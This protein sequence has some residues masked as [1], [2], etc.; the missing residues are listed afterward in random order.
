MAAAA[1]LLAQ[2]EQAILDVVAS[3]GDEASAA[4]VI[5]KVSGQQP[6]AIVREAYWQ[7]ISDNRLTRSANGLLRHP[8]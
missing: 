4:Q 7:L 8:A 5:H 6:P 3:M 2:T 1:E